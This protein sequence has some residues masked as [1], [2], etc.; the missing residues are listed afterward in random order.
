M[1]ILGCDPGG[2]T[3]VFL[4]IPPGDAHRKPCIEHDELPAARF[5]A[6]L[7]NQLTTYQKH[8]DTGQFLLAYERFITPT[9]RAKSAQPDAA[10]QIG[11][12]K[13]LA[14]KHRLVRVESVIK[15]NATRLASNEVLRG[16]GWWPAGQPHAQDAAR[17][18]LWAYAT[19]HPVLYGQLRDNSAC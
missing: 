7:S 18:A 11:V 15:A 8:I 17:V 1:V 4:V 2:V 12:L 16:V 19:N 5:G 14:H 6:Y 13:Y 9:N 3:G 10:E